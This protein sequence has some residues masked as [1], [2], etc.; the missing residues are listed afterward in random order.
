[1]LGSSPGIKDDSLVSLGASSTGVHPALLARRAACCRVSCGCCS[2]VCGLIEL[3]G[4]VG[5]QNQ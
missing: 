5:M 4:A 3:A 2:A 1:M